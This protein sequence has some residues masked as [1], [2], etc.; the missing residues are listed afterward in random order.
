[1]FL[2]NQVKLFQT[3]VEMKAH[4]VNRFRNFSVVRDLSTRKDYSIYMLYKFV[5]MGRRKRLNDFE[6]IAIIIN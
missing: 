4:S 1:M 5:N 6:R 3:K 2:Y